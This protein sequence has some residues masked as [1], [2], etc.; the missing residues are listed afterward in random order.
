MVRVA[1]LLGRTLQRASGHSFVPSFF[2]AISVVFLTP[3]LSL[4]LLS[5]PFFPVFLWPSFL[6]VFHPY[7]SRQYLRPLLCSFLSLKS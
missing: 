4:T 6:H 1:H 3:F 5:S 7:F 2:L